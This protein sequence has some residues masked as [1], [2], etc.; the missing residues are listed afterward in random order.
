MRKYTII[1]CSERVEEGDV[2]STLD[3]IANLAQEVTKL[4]RELSDLR[5]AM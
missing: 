3:L 1:D 4:K 2:K 5:S